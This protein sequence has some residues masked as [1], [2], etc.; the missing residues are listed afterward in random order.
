M[1]NT[2]SP[3]TLSHAGHWKL[4]LRC[5]WLPC[6]H[7]GLWAAQIEVSSPPNL[8]GLVLHLHSQEVHH[9]L[10]TPLSLLISFINNACSSW[11]CHVGQK[12]AGIGIALMLGTLHRCTCTCQVPHPP[13]FLRACLCCAPV[14]PSPCLSV[15]V[16]LNLQ[17]STQSLP[18]VRRSPWF[19]G[20]YTP[21]CPL[22]L[23]CTFSSLSFSRCGCCPCGSFLRVG[24][25]NRRNPLHSQ[26]CRCL[27][28]QPCADHLLR[29]S[30]ISSGRQGLTSPGRS[31]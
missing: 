6:T 17:W 14:S 29:A 3:S 30:L 12:E 19:L 16:L 11:G 27:D 26:S 22:Y 15:T 4:S 8:P 1:G 23:V 9:S 28:L 21:L 31:L 10:D 24:S 7:A 20:Q 25:L 18:L 2:I 5:S 13:P